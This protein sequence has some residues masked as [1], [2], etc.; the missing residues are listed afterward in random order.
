MD[1]AQEAE[2]SWEKCD[3]NYHGEAREYFFAAFVIAGGVTHPGRLGLRSDLDYF[4]KLRRSWQNAASAVCNI[5][6][7]LRLKT[8]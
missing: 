5:S 2:G 1:E 8:Q 7:P 3:E 4:D 6:V